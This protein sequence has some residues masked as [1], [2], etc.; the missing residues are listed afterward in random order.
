MDKR[1]LRGIRYILFA[2]FFFAL[3]NLFVKAA[4]DLP[5][6]QKCFFRNL[7]AGLIATGMLIKKRERIIIGKGNFSYMAIRCIGGTLGILCN[8]Y[9]I[10]KLNIADASMLNKLSPFFCII[11]SIFILKERPNKMEVTAV[12]LAFIGALFVVKPSFRMECVPALF[13]VL[14][15]FGAGLAYTC[16]RKMGKNG[17]RGDVIVFCF[18]VFSC[19]SV[20]P[21]VLLTYKPMETKQLLSLLLAGAAAAGGQFSITAAYSHA[22]AKE[23]SVFDYTQVIFAAVLS[24][25]VFHDLP[26]ILSFIGYTIIIGTAV[27]KWRM[28]VRELPE[29][30]KTET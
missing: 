2:A 17:V 23:I 11:L 24:F 3:M 30:Q 20:I 26:D 28:N 25:V 18:S 7:V 22:P 13:G 6:W 19:V 10:G 4:G 12:V 5:V 27:W 8:F 9:A 1:K 21:G 16:V 15:G 14:G 29:N